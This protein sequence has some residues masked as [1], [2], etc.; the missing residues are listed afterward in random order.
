MPAF[1]QSAGGMLT[2]K[3]IDAL[4]AGIRA[5]W[6]NPAVLQGVTFP[7]YSDQAK[8]D[9][10]R[11][12]HVYSTYCASCHGPD[13]KGGANASSIVEGSLLS[14]ISDQGLRTSVIVGRPELGFPDW[15]NDITGHPMSNQDISDLVSWLVQQRPKFP[16][17]PYPPSSET[18]QSR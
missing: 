7:A 13:G 2:E 16:R 3:Q 15:R 17:Q 11:G 5:R 10:A 12:A 6:A 1:A 4:V 9:P 18:G 8:G 14:L